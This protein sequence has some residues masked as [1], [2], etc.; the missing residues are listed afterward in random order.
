GNQISLRINRQHA[1]VHFVAFEKKRVLPLVV[2]LVN[3]S[4]IA[5]CDIQRAG[6]VENNIPD[7]FGVWIEVR[8][9]NP[10]G[11]PRGSRAALVLGGVVTLGYEHKVWLELVH[12]AIRSR[13]GVDN[14][15]LG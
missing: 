3:F 7:V 11:V 8:C 15:I 9:Y 1:N 14:A 12:L 5:G 10:R 4:M 6:A 2:D 13:S